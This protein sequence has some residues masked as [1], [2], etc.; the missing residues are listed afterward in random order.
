MNRRKYAKRMESVLLIALLLITA[1]CGR[2]AEVL[3]EKPVRTVVTLW[4]YWDI[5]ACQKSMAGL[6]REFN[7]SQDRI[8]VEIRYVPDEDFKKQL[9]L[10]MAEGSMPD[11]AL[12]D[13][14]DFQFFHTMKSFLDLTDELPE[15]ASYMPEALAPCESGGR[16]YGLPFGMNCPALLY[17]EQMLEEAGCSIPRT[18]EEFCNTAV[19]TTGDSHYGFAMAGIQSEESLYAFLPILWSMGGDVKEIGSPAGQEAFGMLARLAEQ[20]ALNCQSVSMTLADLMYQFSKGRVAMMF[21]TS[22]AAVYIRKNAPEI[23]FGVAPVPSGGEAVTVMGGEIIGVSPE[24]HVKEAVEFLHF[25]ADPDRMR[26]YLDEAGFLPPRKDVMERQFPEDE[27][28]QEFIRIFSGARCRE[29]APWWPEVSSAVTSAMEQVI[30][31]EDIEAV[32]QETDG[33]IDQVLERGGA[34]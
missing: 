11:I 25:L 9:A 30:L 29:F 27:Q 20:G 7:E 12:V 31:G 17:N 23:A 22:M 33:E 1:G 18:W 3:P 19:R 34:R 28:M 14:S 4:H 13:S 2:Q 8:T 15:L 6:A 32:L 26:R 16:I 5:P 24:G 21:N 10:S